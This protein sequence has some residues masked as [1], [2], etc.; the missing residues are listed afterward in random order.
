MRG[1]EAALKVLSENKGFASESLRK[2]A[3]HEKM[4]A[5]DISLASSLIYIVMRRRELWAKV[6]GK[7]LRSG[8]KL[9][10]QVY[11]AVL[12]GTGGLMEL[13]RFSEGVL[14]NGIIETLKRDKRNQKYI[15]LV[16]AVLRKVNENGAEI[17]DAMKK[18]SLLDDRALFAGVP[19]WFVSGWVKAW[20]RA[21]LF[22]IFD[23]FALPSYSSV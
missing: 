5:P 2:L 14:I 17:L 10:A 15:S 13:R 11:A 18:S 6:A 8:E 3:E 21:E 19:L 20:S 16:N 7:F 23:M 1:I 22:E 12:T 9:P 4:K